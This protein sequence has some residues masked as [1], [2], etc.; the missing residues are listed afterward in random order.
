MPEIETPSH[1]QIVANAY[2]FVKSMF[3]DTMKPSQKLG[4]LR[5]IAPYRD[6]IAAGEKE[7]YRRSSDE[8]LS[9]FEQTTAGH[10]SGILNLAGNLIKDLELDS[11]RLKAVLT[12]WDD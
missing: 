3:S 2:Y 5:K 10:D 1:E 6:Q 11:K 8:T 7:A 9:E 4:M 12:A